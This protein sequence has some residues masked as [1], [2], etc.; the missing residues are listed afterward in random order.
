MFLYNNCNNKAV[1]KAD[2]EIYTIDHLYEFEGLSWTV[3]E[4][5]DCGKNTYKIHK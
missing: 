3:L 1:K 4:T 5:A 2:V